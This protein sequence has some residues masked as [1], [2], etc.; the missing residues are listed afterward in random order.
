MF[1][2]VLENTAMI[3]DVLG[4]QEITES[5][6]ISHL[7][8]I[9]QGGHS[10]VRGFQGQSTAMEARSQQFLTAPRFHPLIVPI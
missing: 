5:S 1:L 2:H 3:E 9:V 6:L 7:S 4:T 8:C 10:L